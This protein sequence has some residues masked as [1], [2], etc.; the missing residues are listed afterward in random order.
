MREMNIA[1]ILECLRRQSGRSRAELA[2]MTGLTKATVSSLVKELLEARF[3]RESGME[4]GHKGRP[5]TKLVLNH[6]AGC[7]IGVEI[8]IDFISAIL[9]D[10][11]ARVIWRHDEV[12][13]THEQTIILGRV[14][15]IIHEAASYARNIGSSVLGMGIGV[16]G[17]VDVSSGMLLFAGNRGWN[18][19][20]LRTILEAE[21]AFPIYV[22]N[23]ANMAALGES[24]FGAGLGS[25]FVMY[26]SAGV[27]LGGGYVLNRRVLP[28]ATGL[29]GEVGHMTIDLHG[30]V[31]SCGSRGCW[32][33][34]VSQR[35]VF[36]HVQESI[37]AGQ[38]SSLESSTGGDLDRL[39]VPAIVEAARNG[40]SVAREALISCA[41][42]LGVGI[43]NLINALNPGRV[44]FGG[45]LSHAH[46]FMLPVV[47]AVVAE[48][49]LRWTRETCQIVASANGSSACVMGGIAIVYHHALSKPL[50]V[51]SRP[52]A[53]A[54]SADGASAAPGGPST[55]TTA[56][57]IY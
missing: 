45:A 8:G 9:T 5:G 47:E 35:A 41:Y 44:V 26:I 29:A 32:E 11:S 49:A 15:H 37:R 23:D 16:P 55:L 48:R 12:T 14:S 33:T 50:S 30:K 20:P 52:L 10:F 17:L 25:D 28:G 1:L 57:A 39:T 56:R 4:M 21:F 2:A 54:R 53:A 24:Y 40:D 18:D 51:P 6:A 34:L 38:L 42:Y 36:Q 31:C 46:E 7:I 13:E 3:V 27:G 19:V 22:D 43:A